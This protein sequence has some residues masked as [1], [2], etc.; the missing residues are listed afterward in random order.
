MERE[1]SYTLREAAEL[2]G[3]NWRTIGRWI[4][5]DRLPGVYRQNP[6]SPLSKWMIPASTIE[7]V[8]HKRREDRNANSRP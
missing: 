5:E 1:I 6:W 2:L 7:F 8:E 4:A 3:V